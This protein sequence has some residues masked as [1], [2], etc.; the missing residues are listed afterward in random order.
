M[1]I[2]QKHS[3]EL[4]SDEF[5][6]ADFLDFARGKETK[7][8]SKGRPSLWM[9]NA[10]SVFISETSVSVFEFFGRYPHMF[11]GLLMGKGVSRAHEEDHLRVLT[12]L[13]SSQI[14]VM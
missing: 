2:K 9:V 3:H 12:L 8:L 4:I 5:C 6:A 7:F 13:S 14:S 11:L 1:L 10:V